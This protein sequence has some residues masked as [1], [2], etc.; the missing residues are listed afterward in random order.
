MYQV[1]SLVGSGTDIEE[2]SSSDD[3]GCDLSVPRGIAVQPA[4]PL[5]SHFASQ[6]LGV[7]PE[8]MH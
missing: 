2:D 1:Y 5:D 3:E 4:E 7:G 8:G 6:P